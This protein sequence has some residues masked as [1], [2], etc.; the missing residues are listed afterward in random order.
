MILLD[1]HAFVWWSASPAKLSVRA[2]KAIEK[3]PVRLL[4]DISLWEIAMLVELGRLKL[5]RDVEG[6]LEQAVAETA[7]DVVPIDSAIAVRSTRIAKNFHGDPADRLIA[8]T[9]LVRAALLVTA[10]EALRASP[11]LRTVW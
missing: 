4:S 8:A 1:T 11:A 2:R 3:D 7:V 10:D 9:A 6:W 5:D